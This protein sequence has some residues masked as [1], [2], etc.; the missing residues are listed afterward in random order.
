MVITG[1][2]NVSS[3]LRVALQRELLSIL[4]DED[5]IVLQYRVAFNN[6]RWAEG[7][8]NLLRNHLRLIVDQYVVLGLAF[9][10]LRGY[11]LVAFSVLIEAAVRRLPNTGPSDKHGSMKT[12]RLT[13][14]EFLPRLSG[15]N[16]GL[17]L[18]YPSA[19]NV[20][21]H[22]EYVRSLHA[23]IEDRGSVSILRLHIS[24]HY[25]YCSQH[26][27]GSSGSRYPENLLPIFRFFR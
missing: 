15:E 21:L 23:W 14:V 16:V 3:V 26:S 8:L 12:N 5:T 22:L 19:C 10:H 13:P 1:H 17:T 25:W 7:L 20:K 27:L 24:S 11:Y 6:S 4:E 2:F 18:I 9:R